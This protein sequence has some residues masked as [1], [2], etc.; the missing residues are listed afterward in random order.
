M[1]GGEVEPARA[2]VGVLGIDGPQRLLE[3]RGV[4]RRSEGLRLGVAELSLH[5]HRTGDDVLDL[6]DERGELEVDGRLGVIAREAIRHAQKLFARQELG[7]NR[8][9]AGVEH[10]ARL[11]DQLVPVVDDLQT[12]VELADRASALSPLLAEAAP[13][14]A[15]IRAVEDIGDLFQR[16]PHLL[17]VV[18]H[19]YLEHGAARIVAIAVLANHIRLDELHIVV[20]PQRAL[21]QP[22]DLA[23]LADAIQV[24]M[25]GGLRAVVRATHIYTPGKRSMAQA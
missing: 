10:K 20:V 24:V 9:R 5:D 15:E 12:L 3:D 8:Q 18:D 23:H 25:A 2:N 13:D 11:F 17:E 19:R 4:A 7:V 16:Q 1:V 14:M 22:A 6:V 21:G